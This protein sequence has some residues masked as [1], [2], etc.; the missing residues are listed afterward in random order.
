M[1]LFTSDTSSA[2]HRLRIALALKGVDHSAEHIH[3]AEGEHHRSEYATLN[4]LRTVPIVIDGPTVLVQSLA[5]LEYLEE[6]HPEPP[7]LPDTPMARARVR[8]LALTIASDIHPLVT[9]RVL[10]ALEERFGRDG[11]VRKS[12]YAHWLGEGFAALE[13]TLAGDPRTGRYCHGNQVTLADVCLV[14]QAT[15]AVARGVDLSPYPT[16]RRIV[17]SCAALPAFADGA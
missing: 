5:I 3:L 1:K 9:I 14:P 8:G 7:L 17:E 13:R 15:I 12:W 6:I 16:I 11:E 10:D 2:S 4:P